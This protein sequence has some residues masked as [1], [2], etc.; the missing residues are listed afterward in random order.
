MY[1]YVR[2]YATYL[3]TKWYRITFH[4]YFIY[5]IS[6]V[7]IEGIYTLSYY[8]HQIGSMNYHPLFR[9][10][11]WNNGMRCLSLYILK[12]GELTKNCGTSRVESYFYLAIDIMFLW[13]WTPWL[14][15]PLPCHFI[16]THWTHNIWSLCSRWTKM[17]CLSL[18]H[19]YSDVT[20]ATRLCSSL[21]R[22]TRSKHQ[23][24]ALLALWN[25]PPHLTTPHPIPPLSLQWRHNDHDGISNHHPHGCLLNRLLIQ[26]HIKEN[27]KAPRHWPL[28][29]EFTGEFLPQRASNAE[30]VSIWWRHHVIFF[31]WG[32]FNN[33]APSAKLKAWC[34][35]HP[36]HCW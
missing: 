21:F 26:T 20:W 22:L 3:C 34:R 19:H 1:K 24:P 14:A 33:K 31:L 16:L 12:D 2:T 15:R 30:N 25:P 28:C 35:N 4:I 18:I 29:G 9:V 6:L 7:M 23:S 8:H 32:P 17:S 27:N 13:S 10:S 36:S 11:S 5:H